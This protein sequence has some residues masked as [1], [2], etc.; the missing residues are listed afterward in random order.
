MVGCRLTVT[1]FISVCGIQRNVNL[2]VPTVVEGFH[3]RLFNDSNS[4]SDTNVF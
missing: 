2:D 1:V 4:C 3:L